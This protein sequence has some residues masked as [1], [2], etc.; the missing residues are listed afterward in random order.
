MSW[1]AL[2]IRSGER[3]VGVIKACLA[4]LGD[5]PRL[6]QRP[7]SRA[8]W[9]STAGPPP[10][11]PTDLAGGLVEGC[12]GHRREPARLPDALEQAHRRLQLRHPHFRIVRRQDLLDEPLVKR[13]VPDPNPSPRYPVTLSLDHRSPPTVALPIVASAWLINGDRRFGEFVFAR[14]VLQEST[15]VRHAAAVV[16][17]NGST[18]LR[19]AISL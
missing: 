5:E 6:R 17:G 10:P 18:D 1:P 9:S 14:N 3:E 4:A 16:R 8:R 7:W 15:T 19:P 12:L 13:T 11:H 2:S